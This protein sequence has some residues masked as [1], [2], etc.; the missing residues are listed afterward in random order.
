MHSHHGIRQY[1]EEGGNPNE[2]HNGVALF[3][4]MME[5]YTRTPRFGECVRAFVQAGLQFSNEP[6]LC[7]LLDDAEKL[8]ELISKEP[9][10]VSGVHTGV[11]N[12]Y[13][14]LTG[15]TLLHYCAEYN[16]I[17]CARLLVLHGAEIN[18]RAALDEY[19]FGGHTPIFHS[20]NQNNN[21]SK[22]MLLF[23][24]D[25]SADLTLTVKGIIWGQ[26][27]EWETWIP[28]VNPIS[29]AM[30]GLLPQ[31]HRSEQTISETVSLLVKK[32]F[33]IEYIPPNV[34][35]SYLVH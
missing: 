19:G 10:L 13:T 8:G 33:G 2:V 17:E 4:T 32:A 25:N 11:K 3:T 20:V 24:M 6:L 31:M 29:Y 34:P 26:G 16:C 27:Y 21:N 9:G 18:A 12:T 5:M 23:L 30:M 1:F 22:D 28:A 15:G 7:V 35:C 14:P